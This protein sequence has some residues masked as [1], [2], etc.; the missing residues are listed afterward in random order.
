MTNI[1][2]SIVF[3]WAKRG[4]SLTRE[5]SIH[6]GYLK[7][8]S[9][10]QPLKFRGDY[11]QLFFLSWIHRARWNFVCQE[12]VRKCQIREDWM[13][14]QGQ[15]VALQPCK[16]FALD[17][18]AVMAKA[19][20]AHSFQSFRWAQEIQVSVG[21]WQRRV[22]E[23]TEQAHSNIHS[24]ADLLLCPFVCASKRYLLPS[25]CDSGLAS[26]L[27]LWNINPYMVY[28][29]KN[30][31]LT[32]NP[33]ADFKE[34]FM[35]SF[36]E[37]LYLLLYLLSFPAWK[38]L[39]TAFLEVSCSSAPGEL[40]PPSAIIFS[41]RLI[42]EGHKSS[43]TVLPGALLQNF[44]S[45]LLLIFPV[46]FGCIWFLFCFDLFLMHPYTLELLKLKV[47]KEKR[48]SVFKFLRGTLLL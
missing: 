41:C 32:Q 31:L 16:V 28:T 10:C 44:F 29:S 39:V 38:S 45:H 7:G 34:N 6:S 11:S 2:L 1:L 19:S 47:W 27:L 15:Q 18:L 30:L 21:R 23:R 9:S 4:K 3:C 43:A 46:P 22:V 36:I 13:S 42:F 26:S 33:S 35:L 5:L 48:T 17:H 24:A 14:V 12:H 37:L 25:I 20:A 8:K 40:W